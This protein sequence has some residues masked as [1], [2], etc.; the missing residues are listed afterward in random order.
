MRSL[1]TM[2]TVLYESQRQGRISFYM[3]SKGEE[4]EQVGSAAALAADDEMFLQYREVGCLMHRGFTIQDAMHQCFSNSMDKGK[5]RQMP[6]H[7]GSREL[8]VQTVSSPLATQLPQ[9]A[10]AGHAMRLKGDGRVAAVYF[11]EGAASEGDAH[12]ALNFASTLGSRTLFFCRNN[13][14]A[15]STPSAEQYAGDGVAARGPAYGIPTIRCDGNDIFAVYNA[16][17]AARKLIDE[18]NRPA[19]VEAMSYRVGH[20]ST[21]DDAARYRGTEER[22]W[23]VQND[24]P[25]TRLYK[26]LERKGW[27]DEARDDAF[28]AKVRQDVLDA[29]SV[30]ENTPLPPLS[31]IFNDVYAETTPELER[32]RADLKAHLAKYP[33]DYNL[34]RYAGG[35]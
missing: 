2:D 8:H 23:W 13:G 7:Y 11:G 25:L 3:E 30:A 28:R 1:D 19:L 18:T 5:G 10:G 22:E 21:S 33:D 32:Q 17:A 24:N 27:Y 9:A 26:W 6:I 16:T 14:Y 35:L 20:H 4:A 31:E 29:L 12:A 34:E 15:I